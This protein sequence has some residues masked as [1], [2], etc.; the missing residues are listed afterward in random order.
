MGID[1]PD[2]DDRS[3]E[4]LLEQA[5]KLIPAYSEEWT[6]FNPH[7]PGITILE[8]LAWL[9]ETHTYQLDQITDEHRRKYLQLIGHRP[10]PA[11]PATA[12]IHLQ[13]PADVSP[14]RL[15]AGTKLGVADGTEQTSQFETDQDVVLTDAAVT[16][17]I[18]VDGTRT[19][20]HTEANE[21]EGLVYRPFGDD[22][23]WGNA[24]YLGFDRDPLEGTDAVTLWVSYHEQAL[25]EPAPATPGPESDG[26]NP[27]VELAWDYYSSE[28]GEWHPLTTTID[29]TDGFYESGLVELEETDARSASSTEWDGPVDDERNA[30]IDWIRCRVET[31]GYEIPPLVD[32]IRTNV[33]TASHAVSVDEEQLRPVGGERDQDA[34]PALDGQ[35]YAFANSPILSA[36]VFVDGTQ[37]T[38]VP[39][40][41]ASSP[42]DPH[43]VLDSVEGEITFGDGMA[44]RV[45]PADAT[46]S[47]EYVYGGG[48]EGNV[49]SAATWRFLDP[50]RQVA[51]G[52]S[53]GDVEVS[54]LEAASG[55]ADAEPID[56][57]L[58]RARRD[59]RRPHRAVT[60]DDYQ[61]IAAQTPG[62]RIGRTNV[63]TDGEETT[64]IVVPYAPADVPN[65]TPSDA[66]L[67]TVRSHLRE[68]TLL[69][70]RVRVAGPQYVRLEITVS[71]TIRRQYAG[72][73]YESA[74][75]DAVG[76]YLHPLEG[77]DGRGWP[78]GRTL[79]KEGL[80]GEIETVDA[81]DEVSTLSITAHGGTVFEDRTVR[82]DETALFALEDV[83]VEMAPLRSGGD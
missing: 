35:T 57:A 69:T 76:S 52:A 44:G 14:V 30:G 74:I 68:R 71:G 20:N 22:A 82:I 38:E 50:E 64:V 9:T 21:T 81:V 16:R 2:L 13:S 8:I 42:D 10:R 80:I 79:T 19:S 55:G 29:E 1:L 67:D 23:T 43:Y 17:V 75:T 27:S 6:D 66:F 46:V 51:P 4:D 33:V 58:R 63:W 77:Y 41:D 73:G 39:D 11:Q 70:D 48:E 18:A 26:F 65:P 37:F 45:P 54:P 7:D 31:P 28:A 53:V 40:F 62:L 12:M 25:P 47:A 56:A 78:F 5:K 61:E 32:A 49:S 83:T 36:T 34:G 72:S 15:E 24:V 60:E 3:H 59:L